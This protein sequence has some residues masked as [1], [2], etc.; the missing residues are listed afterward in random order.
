M[1]MTTWSNHGTKAVPVAA[2]SSLAK[3]SQKA[4]SKEK[5]KGP[6]YGLDDR[7]L[8]EQLHSIINSPAKRS[9]LPSSS[10]AWSSSLIILLER[11]LL[12][13]ASQL[14]K[15]LTLVS[16]MLN[17]SCETLRPYL[18][19]LL[20]IS[21]RVETFAVGIVSWSASEMTWSILESSC[22]GTAG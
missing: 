21:S 8:C 5:A 16:C 4:S 2:S 17:M 19:A 18:Y 10:L 13:A 14:S 6:Q 3:K 11:N 9:Q 20:R 22:W 7:W 15:A 1:R 12:K